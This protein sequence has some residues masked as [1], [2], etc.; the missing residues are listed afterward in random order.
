M[1]SVPLLNAHTQGNISSPS[2]GT[3]VASPVSKY[4]LNSTE[5]TPVSSSREPATSHTSDVPPHSSSA[6][7]VPTVKV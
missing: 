3:S 6:G 5:S 4:R 7:G 1:V 2:M